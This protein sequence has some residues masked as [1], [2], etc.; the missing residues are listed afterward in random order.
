MQ[1]WEKRLQCSFMILIW[2]LASAVSLITEGTDCKVSQREMMSP[3]QDFQNRMIFWE[4]YC[5]EH[6]FK[7]ALLLNCL[8]LWNGFV[9]A[10]YQFWRIQCFW[11]ISKVCFRKSR[12][13]HEKQNPHWNI[14]VWLRRFTLKWVS[15]NLQ[16]QWVYSSTIWYIITFHSHEFASRKIVWFSTFKHSS[17]WFTS[18]NQSCP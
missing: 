14:Q 11:N 6:I 17:S 16:D 1:R 18:Y 9:N 5:C 12:E 7:S 3:S 8:F 4:A 15:S 2:I 13:K 10:L